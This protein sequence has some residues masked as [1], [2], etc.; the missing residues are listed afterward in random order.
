MRKTNLILAAL[1][2]TFLAAFPSYA[3]QWKQDA[4]GYWYENDDGSYPINQWQEIDG[5]QYYFGA[6]GYMLADTTTP[7][8]YK[9]G[10]DGAWIE[11]PLFDFDIDDSRIAYTGYRTTEDYEGNPCLVL[12]YNFTNKDS[13]PQSAA[14]ADFYITVFQNGVECDTAFIWDDRDDAM[15]NY[16]KDVMQGTTI[17]IGQ[18]YEL[19]DLSDVTIQ[20]KELWNWT[21]PATQTATLK[22]N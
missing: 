18:A 1:A 17:N 11:T 14:F 22:I 21:N 5:K 13:E 8:G 6:D 10:P 12:Y 20:V 2:L 16:S 4:T 15:D 7:D 19:Q 3:G 9:V